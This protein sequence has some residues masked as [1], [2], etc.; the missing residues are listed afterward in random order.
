MC[1]FCRL[2]CRYAT[3][4][5][6]YLLLRRSSSKEHHCT[7]YLGHHKFIQ[8]IAYA[9]IPLLFRCI[10]ACPFSHW[11]LFDCF[12][13]RLLGVVANK[14]EIIS[15]CVCVISHKWCI[16]HSIYQFFST[17]LLC[18]QQKVLEICIVVVVFG[19]AQLSCTVMV[20]YEALVDH[21]NFS[22]DS[23]LI[24]YSFPRVHFT[25]NCFY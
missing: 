24:P 9:W 8:G 5:R 11:C 22:L 16:N 2:V 4:N 21:I 23:E 10:I 14:N 6:I 25:F 18:M 15:I 1:F 7:A 17:Y 12:S 20:R 3:S 19:T 13:L